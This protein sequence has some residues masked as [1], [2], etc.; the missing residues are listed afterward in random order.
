MLNCVKR[1]I[2]WKQFFGTLNEEY[3]T[4][5]KK[6][7]ALDNLLSTGRISQPT[8][9]MFSMEMVE[10]ITEIERRQKALLQKMNA[11]IVELEEQVKT[12]EI[13]LASYEIQHVTGEIDEQTYHHEINVLSMG[14]ET[15][16]ME[17]NSAKEAADQLA[18]GNVSANQENEPQAKEVGTPRE[19]LEKQTV[20]PED[21]QAYPTGA[22]EKEL[23]NSEAS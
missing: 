20:K 17:L 15:S 23:E 11:K 4:A 7:Q 6:R 18:S 16:R 10:A 9:E 21:D 8:Y 5:R 22:S 3:E 19:T 2:L 1:M 12:L 14:L 13:L